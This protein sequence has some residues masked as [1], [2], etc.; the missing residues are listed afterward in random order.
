M[1]DRNPHFRVTEPDI[2][3]QHQPSYPHTKGKPLKSDLGVSVALAAGETNP[4]RFGVVVPEVNAQLEQDQ[5]VLTGAVRKKGLGWKS[6][7]HLR[8][9][10]SSN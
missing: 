10:Q 5:T 2:V 9:L 8:P 3:L 6:T 7:C 1:K 4:P